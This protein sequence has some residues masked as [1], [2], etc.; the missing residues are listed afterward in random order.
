MSDTGLRERISNQRQLL[1]MGQSD[2]VEFMQWLGI[3]ISRGHYAN[4]E[5]SSQYSFQPDQIA[6][7]DEILAL[8]GQLNNDFLHGSITPKTTLQGL[9]ASIDETFEHPPARH[10]P[11]SVAKGVQAYLDGGPDAAPMTI[12]GDDLADAIAALLH[13]AAQDATDP[14]P[15]EIVGWPRVMWNKDIETEDDLEQTLPPAVRSALAEALR[16]GRIVRQHL[17][18]SQET[19]GDANL[20]RVICPFVACPNFEASTLKGDDLLNATSCVVVPGVAALQLLVGDGDH[21]ELGL[22]H[23]DPDVL[24]TYERLA[25]TLARKSVDIVER[26]E[27]PEPDDAA[28]MPLEEVDY[29]RTLAELAEEQDNGVISLALGRFP[30]ATVPPKLYEARIRRRSVKA[31]SPSQAVWDQVIDYQRR[32]AEILDQRLAEGKLKHRC[33]VDLDIIRDATATGPHVGDAWKLPTGAEAAAQLRRVIALGKDHPAFKVGIW[34]GPK[35]RSPFRLSSWEVR[36][37]KRSGNVLIQVTYND[38]R[39]GKPVDLR[40]R[41]MPVVHAYLARFNVIW[42]EDDCL[43]DQE[44]VW[45]RLAELADE[46]EVAGRTA[47][48]PSRRRRPD[49]LGSGGGGDGQAA[50][51]AFLARYIAASASRRTSSGFAARSLEMATPTLTPTRCWVWPSGRGASRAARMR[52]ATMRAPATSDRSAQTTA[53]SS[54][55][56]R[57]TVSVGRTALR[58]R[59]ATDVSSWSPASWPSSSLTDLKRSTSMKSTPTHP[60]RPSRPVRPRPS[61][62]RRTERF[63]QAGERVGDGQFGQALLVQAAGGDVPNEGPDAAALLVHAGH[64]GHL[65]REGPTV[66]VQAVHLP[67]LGQGLTGR[68][69]RRPHGLALEVAL[70][71]VLGHQGLHDRAA[72]AI[73]VLLSRPPRRSCCRW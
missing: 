50:A 34:T 14:A 10:E 72:L 61:P 54:P 25:G 62:S 71:P 24:G 38:E 55:P 15:V 3:D 23:R 16:A 51:A 70:A 32:R 17:M 20:V 67:P 39:Y 26:F 57:A 1:G 40:I 2:V 31:G 42:H 30:G 68:D 28:T 66:P 45:R 53:N 35:E 44:E 43:T 12:V 63:G 64:D 60:S 7:L 37:A 58:R 65:D 29:L 21:I 48:S 56:R 4:L 36:R 11:G 27:R 5:T 49:R 59:W 41:Q 19:K 47:Q 22:L 73:R 13:A 46:L 33:M 69:H 9:A 18:I 52:S 8:G 6:A